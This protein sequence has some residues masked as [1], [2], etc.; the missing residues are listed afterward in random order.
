MALAG[1]SMALA[2]AQEAQHGISGGANMALADANMALRTYHDVGAQHGINAAWHTPRG[3]SQHGTECDVAQHGGPHHGIECHEKYNAEGNVGI[4]VSVDCSA[5]FGGH[6]VERDGERG[7]VLGR[8][9]RRP[10]GCDP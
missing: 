9:I 1:P 6:R 2:G 5:E 8:C 4:K 10:L 3:N 7:S